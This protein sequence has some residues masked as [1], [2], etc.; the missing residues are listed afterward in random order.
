MLSGDLA[1]RANNL[2]REQI[3]RLE[4]AQ[5][6][7]EKEKI[8]QERLQK[9][10]ETIEAEQRDIRIAEAAAVE[11]VS[12]TRTFAGSMRMTVPG[13]MEV[14]ECHRRGCSM[15]RHSRPTMEYGGAP[16]CE[17]WPW[18]Q[19]QLARKASSGELTR[20]DMSSPHHVN[21]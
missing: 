13:D 11:A 20:C 4:A 19:R 14:S 9:Q 8:I 21:I 17:Q 5:R 16:G 12:L 3:Q 15:R 6:K 2:K 18:T 7:A 10:R 1:R